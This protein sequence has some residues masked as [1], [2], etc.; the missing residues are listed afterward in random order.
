MGQGD[1]RALKTFTRMTKFP[2]K[3]VTD[4]DQSKLPAYR[5]LGA[6]TKGKD[7]C[8]VMCQQTFTGTYQAIRRIKFLGYSDL[9]K[10]VG[11]TD[12]LMQGGCLL[13]DEDCQPLYQKMFTRSTDHWPIDELV[14]KVTELNT[15]KRT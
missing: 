2:G 14:A 12:F 6:N 5:A 9:V 3:A 4:L 11:K 13:L 1:Y 8:G 10:G 7:G 15:A